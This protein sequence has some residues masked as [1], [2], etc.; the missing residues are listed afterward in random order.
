MTI[1]PGG[2]IGIIGGGQLGRMLALAA[3]P[4]GYKVHIFD[5]GEA[6]CAGD[7]AAVVTCAAFDDSAALVRF[8]ASV[9]VV[10]YEFE[11]LPVAPLEAL[12]DKL[13]PGTLSLAIAQDR[14]VEKRFIESIGATVSPW[15]EVNCVEDA[16][17]AVEAL[18]TPIVLKSRRLG[19]DGKGQAWIRSAGDAA[20]AWESIGR[21]PAVAERGVDYIAEYSVLVART[22][23]GET[24]CWDVPRNLHEN[25]ILSRSEVP[26]TLPPSARI[27]EAVET[28]RRLAKALGHVGVMAVEYFATADGPIVNEIAPRVHNSGHWTIEGAETSQ[29]EQHV[30]A[31]V[32]LPLGRTALTGRG[33]VMDN[34]IGDDVARWAEFAAEPGAHLHLY[35]KGAARP[36]RKMG[37]VTRVTR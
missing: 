33:A 17:A 21:K 1:A 3:A 28:A 10:T 32:G 23:E 18:G 12:G 8:A 5:P 22:F 14:A 29:F 30:R 6:P 27:E 31:V 11:N 15:C 37:H 25:G 7:V 36:G 20:S 16:V 34:L 26:A 9:D 13:R 35:G 24:R 4:L 2:T 19:Y